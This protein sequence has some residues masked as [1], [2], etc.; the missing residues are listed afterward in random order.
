MPSILQ[1]TLTLL[2]SALGGV[3]LSRILNLPPI[4][5]YL[6]VGL[7][8][9]PNA[10]NLAPD[11]DTVKNLAEFGVVFLMFSIGLEFNLAKLKSMRQI[12]YF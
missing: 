12:K 3:L 1:I 9:G 10:A 7:L 2:A 5:G 4:L 8:I 6:V 11:S